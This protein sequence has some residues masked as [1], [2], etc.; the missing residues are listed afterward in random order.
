[1]LLAYSTASIYYLYYSPHRH[2]YRNII[3]LNILFLLAYALHFI[4]GFYY[5]IIALS[6]LLADARAHNLT[7]TKKY[8]RIFLYFLPLFIGLTCLYLIYMKSGQNRGWDAPGINNIAYILYSFC[9]MQGLGLSR[10]DLR[11]FTW[12]NL[13]T[14]KIF[15]LSFASVSS[16]C[17]ALLCRK[18]IAD[19]LRKQPYILPLCGYLLIFISVSIFAHFRFWERHLIFLLPFFLLFAIQ[20]IDDSLHTQC[21]KLRIACFLSIAICLFISSLRIILLDY[22]HKDDF[23]GVFAKYYSSPPQGIILCQCYGF[24]KKFYNISYTPTRD[25]IHN[26]ANPAQVVDI[27]EVPFPLVMQCIHKA[28]NESQTVRMV[29]NKRAEW[30]PTLYQDAECILR[31]HGYEIHA[32]HHHNIFLIIDFSKK[33][34]TPHTPK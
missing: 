18:N 27:S 13:T 2:T 4:S 9:G 10:I 20:T 30:V 31:H 7:L 22:Y 21:S 19:N 29:L 26:P 24:S 14:S 12:E 17:C 33:H 11:F 1:M 8:G 15:L 16:L 23:K 32:K 6:V 3:I 5:I 28:A 25:F 34:T